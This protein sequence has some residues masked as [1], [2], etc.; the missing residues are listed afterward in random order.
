MITNTKVFGQHLDKDI[1]K[2]F[3]DEYAVAPSEYEKIAKISDAPAGDHYTEAELSPLSDLREVPEGDGIQFDLPV[4]GN[5]KV[6]YY[7]AYGLGF[8]ITPQMYKDDLT[9]NFKQMPSKLAKSAAQKPNVV[10]FDQF[11]SGFA[12]GGETAWD[13]KAIFATD[14]ET[15]KSGETISNAAG[16][17]G[18]LSETTLQAAFEYYDNLIDEAG[19]PLLLSGGFTLLVPNELKY[20]AHKLMKNVGAIGTANNDLNIVNPGNGIVDGYGIH[21]SRYL[22]SSTAWFLLSAEHQHRFFWKDKP[23]LSSADDFYTGN[24]LFKVWER[25]TAFTMD[26]KGTYGNAGA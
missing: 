15:L 12:G 8:Q 7:D 16:T 23:E 19:N 6:V 18:S 1:D 4:E 9:G 2:I 26:Y 10:F 5:K 3:F 20:S 24:A 21:V 14:H 17:A 13:G 22:T 25:F 11:N